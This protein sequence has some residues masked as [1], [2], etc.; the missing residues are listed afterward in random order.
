MVPRLL[1]EAAR[2]REREAAN[3]AA[4]SIRQSSRK[5]SGDR[6]DSVLGSSSH[7]NLSNL[8]GQSGRGLMDRVS[9]ALSGKSF[10]D[11]NNNYNDDNNNNVSSRNN[12]NSTRNNNN[13]NNSKLLQTGNSN[14]RSYRNNSVRA[15]S[16]RQDDN[17]GPPYHG[18]DKDSLQKGLPGKSL[19]SI[20]AT[21]HTLPIFASGSAFVPTAMDTILSNWYVDVRT[22]LFHTVSPTPYRT[23]HRILT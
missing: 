19:F 22:S 12:N 3:L 14:N 17:H 10:Y 20:Q 7:G 8:A 1:H 11:T 21:H 13:N 5:S 18:N 2:A 9:S 4:L 16:P 6:P 15:V 23:H